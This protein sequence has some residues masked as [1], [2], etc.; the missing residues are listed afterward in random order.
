MA[1]VKI[2][3]ILKC[4]FKNSSKQIIKVFFF[5]FKHRWQTWALVDPVSISVSLILQQIIKTKLC[6][7]MILH[8][9]KILVQK[10]L[11]TD[12][13]CSLKL[14]HFFP[15]KALI[16]MLFRSKAF[17]VQFFCKIISTEV[18]FCNRMYTLLIS[19]QK[20]N[21]VYFEAFSRFK[22]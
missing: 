11:K 9:E 5:L 8:V 22:K 17:C 15:P 13:S 7:L 18:P 14:K 20:L 1:S 12:V 6:F 21:R 19:V 2:K 4:V 16:N 10:E 3:G